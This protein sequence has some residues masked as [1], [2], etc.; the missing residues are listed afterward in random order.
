MKDGSVVSRRT[1]LSGA[2]AGAAASMVGAG[3]SM[4]G[5]RSA[6]ATDSERPLIAVSMAP[7]IHASFSEGIASF[8]AHL[9]QARQH[10]VDVIWWTDHDFRVAAH[11]HRQ[12][13]RFEGV[14]ELEGELEWNWAA[15]PEGNLTA[16]AAEFIDEPHSPGEEGKA[17]RLSATGGPGG[18]IF[19]YVGSAWNFTYST[20][21]ADT[22]LELDVLPEQTAPGAVFVVQ[23]QLSYHPARGD[24]PAGPYFLR[25]YVGGST[26]IIRRAEGLVGIVE[27]PAVA[28]QWRRLTLWP[29]RDIH[30]IWPDLVAEDNSFARFRIGVM[31]G[32]GQQVSAV[33]D[34]MRFHRAAREGQAGEFLRRYVLHRY[35]DEYPDVRHYPSFEVSLVRHLNWYGKR[36]VIPDLPSPPYRD[37]DPAK[38]AAM[39][40]FI[41]QHDG[42]ACWNHPLDVE[43]P[44]SLARLMIEQNNLGA[45]LVEIG[46]EPYADLRWVYDVA[47]R[48]AI[49]FTAIGSSDDHGG[50]DWLVQEETHVTSVW[51]ASTDIDD[52]LDAMRA[53]RA[54]FYDLAK[55]RGELDILVGGR[56]AMGGVAVTRAQE[57]PVELVAT[58]LPAGSSLEI[59]TGVADLAGT[60]DLKPAT[61]SQFV[62]ADAL[63]GGRHS[64]IVAPQAGVYVRTQVRAADGAVIALSN[65]VW[66]LRAAPPHGIPAARRL[67]YVN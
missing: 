30:R 1:L 61:T 25:Y 7:H 23:I 8:A 10:N 16:T 18:G 24:R 28:G 38:A 44:E 65:P 51:A 47:A 11:D 12:A 21:L 67:P 9:Q 34:R 29:V 55:Y 13:V 63:G 39:I 33:A 43:Q 36:I 54:W 26:E 27:L 56:R 58:G 22:V 48:N 32:E 5:A 62:P 52:L 53:G 42:L 41:H 66:L 3:A 49:F 59:I 40:D 45:D 46:R 37:D 57:L 15:R 17:L 64:V 14:K 2:A 20:C 50:K 60:T 35:H 6:A 19:W 31:A 4:V